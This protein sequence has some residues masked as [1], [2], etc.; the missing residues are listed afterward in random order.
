MLEHIATFFVKEC[1]KLHHCHQNSQ[2]PLHFHYN[3]RHHL[4]TPPPPA[5]SNL[6]NC[7]VIAHFLFK[8]FYIRRLQKQVFFLPYKSLYFERYTTMLMVIF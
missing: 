3:H 8:S 2:Y 6:S 5:H 1:S 4:S 7:K